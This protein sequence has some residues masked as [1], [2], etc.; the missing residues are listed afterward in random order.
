MTMIFM[1]SMGN[2]YLFNMSFGV[3]G[4]V[5]GQ[6]SSHVAVHGFIEESMI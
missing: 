6:D 3:I 5:D 2:T 4:A 1:M